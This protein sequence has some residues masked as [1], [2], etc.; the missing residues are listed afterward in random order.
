[1]P[2]PKKIQIG[3]T[4]GTGRVP[5]GPDFARPG[6]RNP[7]HYQE[8]ARQLHGAASWFRPSGPLPNASY[9]NGS[10]HKT[11]TKKIFLKKIVFQYFKNNFDFS[12]LCLN[13]KMHATK[14]AA[15]QNA[16]ID[17]CERLFPNKNGIAITTSKTP[18]G[19]YATETSP[20]T[21]DLSLPELNT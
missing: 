11:K 16:C 17:L 21:N 12:Y 8:P 1:M 15:N 18:L 6:K 20:N 4:R 2:R 9:G 3:H 10:K 14:N 13:A 7:E 19:R 5:S